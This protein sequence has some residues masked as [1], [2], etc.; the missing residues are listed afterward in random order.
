[1]DNFDTL[2]KFK[3]LEIAAMEQLEIS[4]RLIMKDLF[5]RA[6]DIYNAGKRHSVEDWKSAWEKEE[7][8]EAP[9]SGE[10]ECPACGEL[11]PSGWSKHLYK[12]DSSI[13][14]YEFK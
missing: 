12:K 14:G 7:K 9:K 6:K 4:G 10:K 5:P 3:A 1:M 8:K 13:C 11:I 2:L